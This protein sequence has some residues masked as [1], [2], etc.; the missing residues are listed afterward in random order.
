MHSHLR[1]VILLAL[2]LVGKK[3]KVVVGSYGRYHLAFNAYAERRTEAA[4][5][6][7]AA[8]MFWIFHVRC[9]RTA[10]RTNRRQPYRR[11]ARA[12]LLCYITLQLHYVTSYMTD[13]S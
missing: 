6:M 3:G 5:V 4:P 9:L 2:M 7:D 1:V 8:L 11:Y 12:A 13:F 10:A